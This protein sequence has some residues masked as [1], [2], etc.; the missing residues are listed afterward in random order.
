MRDLGEKKRKFRVSSRITWVILLVLLSVVFVLVPRDKAGAAGEQ[1]V[2]RPNILFAIA[3]DWSWPHAGIYGDRVVKTPTLDRLAREGVL[4]TNAYCVS[5]SCTPSRGSILTGQTIHRLEDGGNLWSALPKKFETFPDLLE[6]A[7]YAVGYQEKGWGPGSLVVSGRTRNPAGPEFENFEEF[8]QSVPEGKPFCFWFGSTDPHRPYILDSGLV[9]G[10]TLE[11]VVVPP[12]LPDTPEVRADI[13]DYYWEVQRFDRDVGSILSLLEERGLLANTMVVMT[14]DNGMPF[15]RAKANLYD[16]GTRMPLAIRWPARVKGGRVVE[17]FVSFTDFAPTFLEAADLKP[18]PEMTGESLLGLLTGERTG[19]RDRVFLERE[20]HANARQGNLS[21]PCRAVRTKQ[22]LYIRNLRPDR[23]PAGDPEVA[24]GLAPPGAFTDVDSSP[25]KWLVLGLYGK[26]P[27]DKMETFY[28]RI[29]GKRPAE[30][31]YDLSEDPAQLT[32]VAERPEY[33]AA[34]RELRAALDRW[35]VETN[36][37]RTVDDDD[38]W[39]NYP[40][41]GPVY[42]GRGEVVRGRPEDRKDFSQ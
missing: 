38:R 10:M 23:W 26:Y 3:D 12:F 31:L 25:T 28:R 35:M 33:S 4:F 36:D 16:S 34:K 21:Y 15:P 11:D 37:P 39:D 40:Y 32:N 42:D 2:D 13:L 19:H 27:D 29:F 8:L 17:D 14:S 22:F 6:A 24:E 5:P 30:E 1:A 7:G 41:F 20:R 18:L 9:S